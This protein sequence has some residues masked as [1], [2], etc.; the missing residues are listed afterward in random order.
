MK[1][2]PP[3]TTR[4]DTRFPYTTLFRSRVEHQSPAA[5][6][7]RPVRPRQGGRDGRALPRDQSAG[8]RAPGGQLPDAF[9]HGVAGGR[10]LRRGARRLRQLPQ[11]GRDDRLVPAPQA[12]D[13]DGGFRRWPHRPDPGARARPVEDRTRRDAGADP[14]R[15]EEHTSELQSLMRLSYAVF[16]LKKK[17]MREVIENL[18]TTR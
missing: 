9:E 5:R 3:R 1:L 16:C 11:Q 7:R 8:R 2:R 6:A 4:T 17:N 15:S 13:R 10:W 14:A 18:K 12:A